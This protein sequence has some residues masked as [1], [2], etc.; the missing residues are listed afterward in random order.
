MILL[1]S[2]FAFA[3]SNLKADNGN[4]FANVSVGLGADREPTL[5]LRDTIHEILIRDE[6]GNFKHYFD[7][8]DHQTTTISH[9]D[10]NYYPP[11]KENFILKL[12]HLKQSIKRFKT[13]NPH[14]PTQFVLALTGHGIHDPD[15]NEYNFAIS[16]DEELSGKE[17]FDLI[18]D[19]KA[20]K[21]ILIMQSCQSG[22]LACDVF[23]K[24][25]ES[26]TKNFNDLRKK[27]DPAIAVLTPVIS[28][29]NSPFYTWEG[30]IKKAFSAKADANKNKSIS[31]SEWLNTIELYSIL[32]A[33]YFPD[34]IT[35][36]VLA[37]ELA[38]L[39]IPEQDIEQ[40]VYS[41]HEPFKFG[42]IRPQYYVYGMDPQEILFVSK[43]ASKAE[44]NAFLLKNYKLK[45]N[46]YKI[47]WDSK[48]KFYKQQLLQLY[49]KALAYESS[50]KSELTK[51]A[52]VQYLVS[53]PVWIQDLYDKLFWQQ[54]VIESLEL[55]YRNQK[56]FSTNWCSKAFL[57]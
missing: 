10:T 31:F 32:N 21:T 30:I 20:D 6:A 41:V 7:I 53:S 35:N 36:G 25:G 14:T 18:K 19:V 9:K 43:Q 4:W 49:V 52:F 39:G 23:N 47:E 11:S 22:A 46:N 26:L 40:L 1:I 45:K 13:R 34:F 12:K 2:K 50:D 3:T 44:Q 24:F 17:I 5:L 37:N 54:D 27:N 28:S 16:E 51:N 56:H 57:P 48:V 15:N 38:L 42:G 29:L 8:N 33:R 55:H